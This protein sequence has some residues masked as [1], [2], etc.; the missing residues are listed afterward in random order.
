MKISDHDTSTS[1]MDKLIKESD[2]QQIDPKDRFISLQFILRQASQT[3][4]GY[5]NRRRKVLNLK[6]LMVKID[7][8]S[9][10]RFTNSSPLVINLSI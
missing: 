3:G 1:L 8:G 6:V 10:R 2:P 5:L 7:V 4:L 9:Q